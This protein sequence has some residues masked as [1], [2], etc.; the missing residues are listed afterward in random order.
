VKLNDTNGHLF[1]EPLQS[2]RLDIHSYLCSGLQQLHFLNMETERRF[3]DRCMSRSDHVLIIDEEAIMTYRRRSAYRCIICGHKSY[4]RSL[5][6]S[7][8]SVY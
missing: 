7:A 6:P 1:R 3:C 4:R 5:R 8:E 2:N